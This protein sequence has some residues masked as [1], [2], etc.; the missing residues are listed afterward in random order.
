MLEDDLLKLEY[1]IKIINDIK[2]DENKRRKAEHLRRFEIYQE[3]QGPYIIE[4]LTNEFDQATV[5]DMRKILSINL[6]PRIIN[7]QAS[8][9]T[10]DV[11]REFLDVSPIQLE[12]LQNLY[13]KAKANRK[14]K[15]SN[16]YFKLS[17]QTT[18][19]VIPSDGVIELRPILQHLYDVIPRDDN[20]EKAMAYVLSTF[21]KSEYVQDLQGSSNDDTKLGTAS[22][23]GTFNQQIDGVNQSIADADDY[24]SGLEKYIVWSDKYHFTM[25]GSGLITSEDFKNPIGKLP[26]IDVADD[27]DQEFFCRKGNNTIDFVLDFGLLL[28]DVANTNRLQSYAQAVISSEKMPEEMRLGPNRVLHLKINPSRP[29]INPTFAFVAPNVDLSGSLDLLETY[30]KLFL[31]AQGLDP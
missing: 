29:E 1:R 18:M 16:R 14:Y 25:N 26:F 5:N 21:D 15:K 11:E 22:P 10:G 20:N 31:S 3:R 6:A 28:S 2:S 9:Y 7:S 24:K 23:S 8:L 13:K 19:Q 12:Q 17:D 27:K 30:L 4:R